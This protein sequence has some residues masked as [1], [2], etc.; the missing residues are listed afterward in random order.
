MPVDYSALRIKWQE[1]EG[2]AVPAET[3]AEAL[4]LSKTSPSPAPTVPHWV[5]PQ[6][7]QQLA[8]V[9]QHEDWLRDL[10]AWHRSWAGIFN[11]P[12]VVAKLAKLNAPTTV[13][14]QRRNRDRYVVVGQD[15]HGRELREHPL[16]VVQVPGPAWW[17]TNGYRSPISA[18][19]LEAVL[20][21]HGEMLV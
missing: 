8:D 11:R 16:E 7:E 10:H 4:R 19:D 9:K 20:V 2:P 12:E 14:E 5:N 13:E 3:M 6:G 18:S 17:Q 15:D 1:L 21:K